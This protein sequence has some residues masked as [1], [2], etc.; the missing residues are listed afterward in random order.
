MNEL[1]DHPALDLV[2]ELEAFGVR[3]IVQ[4]LDLD[5]AVPELPAAARLLLVAPV[6]LRGAADRLLVGHARGLQRNLHAEALAQTVHDHL[7][8]HLREARHD[9]LAGLRVAVQVDRRVLLL[10]AAQRR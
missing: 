10:Q 7:H 5:L 9:L 6:R 2:D 1:G 3:G 8:V 4:R